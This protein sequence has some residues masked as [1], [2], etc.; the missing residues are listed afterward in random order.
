MLYLIDK[1]Y[2][3][4]QNNTHKVNKKLQPEQSNRNN[5]FRLVKTAK[6]DVYDL[7]KIN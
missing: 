3:K 4:S 2:N 5:T 6:P 7:Y 1:V